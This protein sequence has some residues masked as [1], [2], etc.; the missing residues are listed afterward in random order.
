METNTRINV[1]GS[2][3]ALEVNGEPLRL[4]RPKYIPS[5]VRNTASSVKA[6]TGR[7]FRVETTDE[8]ITVVRIS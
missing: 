2:I 8:Q 6:D 5:I 7:T 3:K 1:R 4:P